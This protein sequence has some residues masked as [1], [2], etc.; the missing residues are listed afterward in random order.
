MLTSMPNLSRLRCW[1]FG[2]KWIFNHDDWNPQ[3]TAFCE[4]CDLK[5]YDF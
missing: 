5:T 4:W 2:H 1:L 3:F